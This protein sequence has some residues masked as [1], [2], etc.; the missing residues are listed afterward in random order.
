[1]REVL[2]RGQSIETSRYVTVSAV[3][4]WTNE[5]GIILGFNSDNFIPRRFGGDRQHSRGRPK[6][7][8]DFYHLTLG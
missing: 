1:M 3:S 8:L 2:Q 7:R 5:Q 4:M 6:M